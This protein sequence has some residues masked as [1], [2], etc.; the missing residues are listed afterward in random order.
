MQ[1]LLIIG[2]ALLVLYK[3]ITNDKGKKKQDDAKVREKKIANGELI[4]DPSC[5]TYVD[6]DNAISVRDGEKRYCFCSYECRDAFIKKLEEGGR[7]IPDKN[8]E[9]DEAE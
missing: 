3:L 1:K 9:E 4:Q 7:A 6:P 5:G 2:I 8:V